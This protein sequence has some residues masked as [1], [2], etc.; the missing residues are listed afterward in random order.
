MLLS[1]TYLIKPVHSSDGLHPL[2]QHRNGRLLGYQIHIKDCNGSAFHSNITLNATTTQFILTN[3]SL[4]QEYTVRAVSFTKIGLG[5]FSSPLSFKMDPSL[6]KLDSKGSFGVIRSS[7]SNDFVNEPW[8][9]AVLG[10]AIIIFVVA[11]FVGIIVYRRNWSE[12][13]NAMKAKHVGMYASAPVTAGSAGSTGMYDEMTAR[14]NESFW[15][16]NS[17]GS[18]HSSWNNRNHDHQQQQLYAEV[19]DLKM[20]SSFNN[21][22]SH[23]P[24]PYATTTLAMQNR[25]LNSNVS[26]FYYLLLVHYDN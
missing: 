1:V 3:L 5:P 9:V 2:L 10:S 16:N 25:N 4:G 17:N 7:R 23:E 13:S 12:A 8:F 15:I 14:L 21:N 20:T 6:I 24:A 22:Q 26:F 18:C 11:V 19:N